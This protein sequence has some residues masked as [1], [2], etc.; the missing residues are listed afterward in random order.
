M[1][2]T[3]ERIEGHYEV[4]EVPYGKAYR[5]GPDCAIIECDCGQSM[6]VQEITTAC[7]GCGVSYTDVVGALAGE[8]L[9]K[10]AHYL[11]HQEYGFSGLF[12]GLKAQE[13][14]NRLLDKLY[15]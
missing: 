12:S 8:P 14:V 6:M 10:A 13:E 9:K 3:E 5:W 11:G 1:T 15:C 7:P 4:Q 2:T